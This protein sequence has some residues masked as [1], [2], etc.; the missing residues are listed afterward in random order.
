MVHLEEQSKKHT[1]GQRSS[2]DKSLFPALDS[3]SELIKLCCS[4]PKQALLV[5][6][7]VTRTVEDDEVI[8]LM[9]MT[10]KFAQKDNNSSLQ[11]CSAAITDE[12]NNSIDQG[13]LFRRNS[14]STKL[15]TMQF[16]IH[17]LAF[18]QTVLMQPLLKIV[19]D[20]QDM[21]IDYDKILSNLRAQHPNASDQD[22][23][24]K[25][26]QQQNCDNLKQLSKSL[27][28][29]TMELSLKQ[30]P[31]EL[32]KVMKVMYE[33]SQTKWQCGDICVGALF[34]LR[35]LC[36]AIIS[37][38]LFGITHAAPRSNAQR[39]LLLL[40]KV[41]QSIA[42]GV[43]DTSKKEPFMVQL[44]SFIQ[45]M[46]QPTMDFFKELATVE[47]SER[48]NSLLLNNYINDELALQ[49]CQILHKSVQKT[50]ANGQFSSEDSEIVECYQQMLYAL[51]ITGKKITDCPSP[52]SSTNS[53]SSSATSSSNSTTTGTT[54]VRRHRS[55]LSMSNFQGLLTGRSRSKNVVMQSPPKQQTTESSSESSTPK[56]STE[57]IIF[58]EVTETITDSSSS[59]KLLFWQ[60][61]DG[62][63]ERI[64][65]VIDD[66]VTAI[67]SDVN[68]Q[69]LSQSLKLQDAYLKDTI[70]ETHDELNR[71]PQFS[72][73]SVSDFVQTQ[74]AA[75]IFAFIRMNSS[76]GWL[77][78][79]KA[80][81][82]ML[83][84]LYCCIVLY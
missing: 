70:Q 75:A 36:P 46:R 22:A 45:E 47:E 81:K 21:E 64:M 50:F 73:A 6:N 7:S 74:L 79:R 25:K 37:P 42:N 12:L 23:E 65:Q 14:V 24:A 33:E 49:C 71:L 58:E 9:V 34:F 26:I 2:L 39:T 76:S 82:G 35:F 61:Q 78:V 1:S 80:A 56:E 32:R 13:T 62:S 27:L 63:I 20:D 28:T 83:Y 29:E 54:P 72:D 19:M 31:M 48:D 67:L 68:Q 57:D 51:R 66:S 41:L 55:I 10:D 69:F 59:N 17:G 53:S 8:S 77:T 15:V 43:T 16:R 60:E 4:Q 5:M 40:T 84:L 11:L 38:H 52:T 3:Y 44:H 30:C 18:L